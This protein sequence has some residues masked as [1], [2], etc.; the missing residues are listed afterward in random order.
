[1]N[2]ILTAIAGIVTY[3]F[4]IKSVIFSLLGM[5]PTRDSPIATDSMTA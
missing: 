1:M 3:A 4:V 5:C 2:P